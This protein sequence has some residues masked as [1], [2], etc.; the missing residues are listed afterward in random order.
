[1][2]Q[3]TNNDNIDNTQE[4]REKKITKFTKIISTIVAIVGLIGIAILVYAAIEG[5]KSGDGLSVMAFA[6]APF[7]LLAL[8]GVIFLIWLIRV[9]IIVISRKTNKKKNQ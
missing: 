2:D 8:G 9:I 4:I 3:N 1:M 5:Y 7:L 6:V